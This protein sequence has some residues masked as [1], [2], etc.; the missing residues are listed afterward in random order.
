[1]VREQVW[2]L[3]RAVVYRALQRL[4]ELGLIS[5]TGLEITSSGPARTVVSVT[6]EG[7]APYADG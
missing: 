7:E 6:A 5:E 2:S 4:R 3:R 1:L